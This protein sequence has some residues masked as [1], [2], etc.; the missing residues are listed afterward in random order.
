MAPDDEQAP[1][2]PHLPTARPA[3]IALAAA[4]FVSFAMFVG[5]FVFAEHNT[6][7]TLRL[8][9]DS[10]RSLKL[11][12]ELRND[13]FALLDADA[14]ER[15]ALA[16][17]VDAT[18]SAYAKLATNPGE[19]EELARLRPMLEALVRAPPNEQDRAAF[20]RI[21]RYSFS[22]LRDINRYEAER[23]LRE[24]EAAHH[25]ALVMQIVVA[26]VVLGASTLAAFSVYRIVRR[27]RRVIARDVDRLSE[28]NRDL[29]AFAGRTA[30]DLRGPL[31]PIRGYAEMLTMHGAD[32]PK[33]AAQIR[34]ATERMSETIETLLALALS[35]HP[36]AGTTH[37]EPVL[38]DVLGELA[39]PLAD[40]QVV[41]AVEDTQIACA[42]GVLRQILYNLVENATKYR[43]AE[44]D[45]VVRIEGKRASSMFELSIE[46]NGV[47]MPPE[48]TARVFEPY[49]RAQA[50]RSRPGSGLGLTIVRRTIEAIGG[51]CE[52]TSELGRGTRFLMRVPVA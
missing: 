17:R 4:A 10:L 51:E 37:V 23:T 22:R 16:R 6:A 41:T 5:A 36:P 27:Q 20:R 11:V 24:L 48:V 25:R 29:A 14:S 15:D 38:R 47:G 31:T 34:Q 30:H 39:T 7:H 52:L 18:L 26:I 12:G 8:V 1:V 33:A 43:A 46:D 19:A 28:R 2:E 42:P 50:T 35:G 21:I 13:T 45:L 44:R 49:Y 3:L 40:A 32:I 9:D